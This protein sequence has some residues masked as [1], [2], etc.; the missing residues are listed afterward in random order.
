[1]YGISEQ[2]LY[3]FNCGTSHHSY[4]FMG[5]HCITY[6]GRRG[7]RFAVWAPEAKAVS[8]IGD[9]NGWVHETHYLQQ[10]NTSGIFIGFIPKVKQGNLYKYYITSLQGTHHIKSDP[11]AFYS[12]LRP[13]TASIVNGLQKFKWNDKQW[14]KQKRENPSYERPMLIYEVHAGSWKIK[15]KEHYYSY[16]ELTESLVPYVKEWGYTHIELMPLSEHPLDQSW[17]YQVTGFYSPTSRYGSPVQLKK[18]V[19]ACH[20]NGIGVILDWVP[21]HFC[22]DNH[23]LREFDG[24]PLY[25]GADWKRADLP[26]WGTLSFDYSRK[27]VISFL[28]SNAIYW[29]DQFHFD[30]LRVDAVA[31]MLDLHMDKPPELHTLN[32]E[33]G[34]LNTHA[35]AFLR[36]MNETIFHYYPD[37]LMLAEDSSSFAS[38]TRPTD[39][40]GLGFNYKWNMGW[41]NDTLKYLSLP[42][43]TRKEK[44]HLLTFSIWYAFNENYV[45]PL[46]HDEVVHGKRSLLNKMWG[47]YEQK[48]AQLRMYYC[49][50]ITHPGKK[51]LFMGGEWGQFDEWKDQ[52]MLDWDVLEYDSHRNMHQF[53]K[54]LNRMY[55][56]NPPLWE[57][58]HT[59]ETFQWID[60]HNYEQS[61][62]S[63]SRH[64]QS[65]IIVIIVNFSL[66]Y[67]SEY[68][69][70]VPTKGIYLMIMHSNEVK[71]GGT[72]TY[73]KKE[74]HTDDGIMHGKDQSIS[75]E[76]PPFTCL[77]YKLHKGDTI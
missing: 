55:L 43:S 20:R 49:Y 32:A 3:L 42:P 44:H 75:I 39:R 27:E 48:F 77:I 8:V 11:Y 33:G 40:G 57:N 52:D 1:M 24:S 63:Y 7:T 30:G 69:V 68:R 16:E 74:V 10:V 26:L 54:E 4:R 58:D 60:V 35:I 51:L 66:N 73:V 14:Y 36:Y 12:E 62:L 50:W 47:S 21:G 72:S 67:F 9:F 53:S 2:D 6:E 23:G 17:G 59:P 56:Q 45:L 70:G 13:N 37:V 34:H 25:E 76:L 71:Y 5:A 18:F 41:M 61:I 19:N 46:S 28:V 15:G 22:R 31:N 29:L 64:S 65:G 38:V